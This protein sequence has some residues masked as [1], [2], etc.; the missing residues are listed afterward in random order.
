MRRFVSAEHGANIDASLSSP[1]QTT[2]H[3]PPRRR[4]HNQDAPSRPPVA[5][6]RLCGPKCKENRS[7][8]FQTIQADVLGKN[9][10]RR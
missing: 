7:Q 4:R 1:G 2:L 8:E 9:Y 10:P 6:L 5:R 3:Y